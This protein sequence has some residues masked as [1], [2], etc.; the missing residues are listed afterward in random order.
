MTVIAKN[1]IMSGFY[2]DPSICAV[3]EDYYLVNSTFAYFPG[4]PIM[5]S[6]D[7]VHWEQI[8]NAMDRNSQLPLE[9]CGHSQGLFAP[10]IRYH[11]GTYYVIC[12]NV[13]HGGNYIITATSPEGPWSEPYYLEGAQGIDPSLFFDE[14]GTCYYIGTRPNQEGC[15]YGGD[16]YIWIQQLDL[17]EMKLI[18]EPKDVWNGAMKNIV[19]PEGPHLY[20][21]NGYYYVMHA[22]GGTGPDHAVTI[23]R[24]RDIWGPYENNF[25]NPIL[26]H[27]H[28]G[29]AYPIKYVGHADMIETPKGD[30]YMVMLAV[31]PLEGYTT[32]G[33]ETFLAKVTWENDWP[34]VNAGVGMLTD[35]VEINLDAWDPAADETSYTSRTGGKS[36]VPGSNRKYDFTSKKELGDEFVMLRNPKADMYNLSE[37]GLQLSFGCAGLQEQANP[38]YVGIRQ[39]HHRFMASAW[40]SMEGIAGENRAGIALL[41]SNE[42]H[43]RLEVSE[44]KVEAILCEKGEDR[45]LG[46]RKFE[47]T[48]AILFIVVDGLKATV[49]VDRGEEEIVI[50]KD[51]DIR[52]LSTEVAGGFV[53]CTLGMYAVNESTAGVGTDSAEFAGAIFRNFTYEG[54]E[55]HEKTAMEN[56]E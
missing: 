35:E 55:Q 23:C 53:G 16:W 4:L 22:E 48:D 44:D 56:R 29:W 7:L 18:G 27:R 54:V 13:S 40:L 42:Y 49:G 3:G 5:H 20:K 24:S 28:L 17:K 52:C 34:V 12:T 21:K 50:A 2:P 30:W 26:T 15:K 8:G 6:R 51:I 14:D 9:N 43:L 45:S 25:C 41:Q 46:M 1:P 47:D 19:W 38:S 37:K 31:R 32:M 33:R 11:E 10:T 39:Q 36:A